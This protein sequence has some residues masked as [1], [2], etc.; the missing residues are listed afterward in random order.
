ML[1]LA[2]LQTLVCCHETESKHM[3]YK[4]IFKFINIISVKV[5]IFQTNKYTLFTAFYSVESRE[6]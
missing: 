3:H 5:W 1:K 6:N 4:D 2:R